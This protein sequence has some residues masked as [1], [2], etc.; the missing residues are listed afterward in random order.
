MSNAKERV[1][2]VFITISCRKYIN[3]RV[4][5][6]KYR[7]TGDKIGDWKI[8]Y[9]VCDPDLDSEYK[10]Q[11]I[12]EPL[13]SNLLIIKGN[14]DYVHL[15]EKVVKAQDIVHKLFD[16]SEGIIK[17]DDDLLLNKRLVE[18]FLESNN[19]GEFRGRN[20]SNTSFPS[21]G[22]EYCKK[23]RPDNEMEKYYS[24]N[25]N[26]LIEIRKK[27]PDFNPEIYNVSPQLPMGHGGCGGIYFLSTK[28]SK[29]I[30]DYF[31]KCDFDVFHYDESSQ[32]YP[33]FA[34]DVGTSFITCNYGIVYTSD[35][36]MFCHTSEPINENALGFHTHIQGNQLQMNHNVFNILNRGRSFSMF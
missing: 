24:K 15:F 12:N 36:N 29:Q 1:R 27:I 11:F 17:C 6:N 14:D 28:V 35:P 16:V 3:T 18:T 23:N 8:I 13:N 26:E 31:K 33:F 30:V 9:V 10:F 32:S 22:P 25:P 2:G 4:I 21:P 34:E 7:L 19:K 5:A 20:Y